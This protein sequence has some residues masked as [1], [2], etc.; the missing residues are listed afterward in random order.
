MTLAWHLARQAEKQSAESR[1]GLKA[2]MMA[3]WLLSLRQ[4]MA[5]PAGLN[6][7]SRVVQRL[8]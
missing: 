7:Q 2:V 1:G 3:R 5:R 6:H 4:N 8:S